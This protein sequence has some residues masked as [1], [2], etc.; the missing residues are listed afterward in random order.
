[1][2]GDGICFGVIAHVLDFR[3]LFLAFVLISLVALPG[4]TFVL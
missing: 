1:M 2:E 3:F 4:S